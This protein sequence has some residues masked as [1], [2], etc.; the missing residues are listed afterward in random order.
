[1]A[2]TFNPMY[3]MTSDFRVETNPGDMS[4]SSKEI[5]Q[6]LGI[7]L[8]SETANWLDSITGEEAFVMLKQMLGE[9]QS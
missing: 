6:C 1:M 4:P 9:Q 5:E 8:D 3:M 2:T 7:K